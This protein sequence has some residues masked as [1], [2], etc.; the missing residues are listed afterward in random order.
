MRNRPT[1]NI[2]TPGARQSKFA[3]C[4]ALVSSSSARHLCRLSRGPLCSELVRRTT[5]ATPLHYS[6]SFSSR[7]FSN[8]LV[9]ASTA[10]PRAFVAARNSV[11]VGGRLLWISRQPR[12][13]AEPC[14]TPVLL[15]VQ[16]FCPGRSCAPGFWPR[17]PL[18][19]RIRQ[20]IG[21][22]CA[23]VFGRHV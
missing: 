11:H 9:T 2:C 4:G 1:R 19:I 22:D 17:H 14:G 12:T 6:S 10:R 18:Q 5:A 16:R 8:S 15:S 13:Q 21:L 23:A 20:M 3:A 7:T